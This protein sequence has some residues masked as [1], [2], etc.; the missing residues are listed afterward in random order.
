MAV[1]DAEGVSE[2]AEPSDEES[3][4]R[5]S[6]GADESPTVGDYS[7]EDYL[8]EY[9][10][11]G[12]AAELASSRSTRVPNRRLEGGSPTSRSA[13]SSSDSSWRFSRSVSSSTS[14][15]GRF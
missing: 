6:S 10:P 8:D 9:G 14:F 11:S 3:T 2:Q 13:R 15:R 12:V 4:A 7:W 5:A 1:D